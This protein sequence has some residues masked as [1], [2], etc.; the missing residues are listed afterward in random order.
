MDSNLWNKG[1]L[2]GLSLSGVSWI[3][4]YPLLDMVVVAKQRQYRKGKCSSSYDDD[5]RLVK[6]DG[7][8][9][10]IS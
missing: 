8:R 1:R 9:N 3:S 2:L 6:L 4:L 7:K 10:F 5:R